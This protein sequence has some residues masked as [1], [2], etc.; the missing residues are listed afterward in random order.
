MTWRRVV[1]LITAVL[2]AA[3]AVYLQIGAGE[4][5]LARGAAEQAAAGRTERALETA[6]KVDGAPADLR[7]RLV[8][9][10]SLV[11]LGRTEQAS[12]A[13]AEV[14]RRDPN[15]WLVQYEWARATFE[16]EPEAALERLRR[17]K[18]LNPL[19]PAPRL[20]AGG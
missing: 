8:E 11:A 20:E 1:S 17:A 3:T 18:A 5:D 9:A 15:N 4:A 10:R 12:R 14:A 13:Y 6:R 7:A 19:L 2:C 16:A